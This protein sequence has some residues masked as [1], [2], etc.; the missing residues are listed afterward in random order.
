MNCPA[1]QGLQLELE[2]LVQG[3]GFRPQLVLRATEL[4]LTGWIANSSGG[5]KLEAHGPRVQLERFVDELL[6]RPPRFSQI[7]KLSRHW[8]PYNQ[9]HQAFCIAPA[10]REGSASALLC[11]DLA[12]CADC[13]RELRDPGSRRHQYPF[14]SCTQCGPRYSVTRGLPFERCNT[15]Y[16]P[17]SLCD[18]CAQEYSDPRDRRFHAQT[19]SC[20]HCGP[21]LLWNGDVVALD[22]GLGHATAALHRGQIVAIQG[23]GGF[24]LLADPQRS[25][26]VACLRARKGRP[27]KPLALLSSHQWLQEL[28]VVSEQEAELFGGPSAPIVLLRRRRNTGLDAGVAGSSPWLGVMRPASALQLLLLES[29]GRPLI[30]TSANRSGEPICRD[31]CRDQ[32]QLAELCDGVLSHTAEIVNRIDD[33]VVREAAKAPLVLRLGRGL[34]PVAIQAARP[35]SAAVGLGAQQKGALAILQGN[36]LVLS[37]DLGDGS[38][39]AGLLHLEDTLQ[40]WLSRHQLEPNHV[41]CDMHPGY[42]ST[43]LAKEKGRHHGSVLGL[44]QHHHAHVLAVMAEHAL[45]GP[46]LGVA[47]D[48]SGWGEDGSLWGGEFLQVNAHSVQRLGHLSPFPLIGGER[49]VREPRRVALALLHGSYGPA[50]RERLAGLR[51]LPWLQSFEAGE[52]ELLEQSLSRGPQPVNCSSVGRLFDAVA[53]LLG[54][55]QRCSF[56]AQAAIALEGLAMEAFDAGTLPRDRYRLAIV[57]GQPFLLAW[58]PLLEALLVDLER[59]R[60]TAEIAYLFHR[61]LAD[62]LPAVA[63]RL[64]SRELVLAGGCFQNRLLLELSLEALQAKGIAVHWSQRLPSNDAAIPLGQLMTLG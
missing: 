16:A 19:I 20:S 48:G 1:D 60:P 8:L 52:L 49:A 6:Q 41:L 62:A 47:W 15:S 32:A 64:E 9:D 4:G 17:F 21:E 27:D 23:I 55:Q 25:E 11:P 12:L 30:A 36:Q 63:A 40:Q 45:T 13:E 44:V 58:Q 22:R 14:I 59:G 51:D 42:G 7:T 34:A 29:F 28:C 39:S 33:S 10:L 43:Q 31:A 61:A 5:V 2:G 35:R 37:P 56:E 50:W 18:A 38:N 46:Q 54:V 53:A 57:E 3:I 24:Q 26:T